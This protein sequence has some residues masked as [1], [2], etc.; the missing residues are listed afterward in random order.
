MLLLELNP[1]SLPVAIS[2]IV[3]ALLVASLIGYVIGRWITKGQ[4]KE[5]NEVLTMKEGELEQCKAQQTL[6]SDRQK[7]ASGLSIKSRE[8]DDLKEIEGIGPRI[9]KVLNS[10]QIFRFAELASAT[11]ERLKGILA[12]AGPR[13][14]LHDPTSWPEQASLARDGKWQELRKLQEE[15]LG[16]QKPE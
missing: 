16:G 7:A 15:L 2:E 6:P 14:R 13:F 5:L 12:E 4:L 10:E 1:L 11:P 9:E 3:V 8:A